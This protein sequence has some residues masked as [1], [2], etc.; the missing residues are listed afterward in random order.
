M[1]RSGK[2]GCRMNTKMH[3]DCSKNGKMPGAKAHACVC[4]DYLLHGMRLAIHRSCSGVFATSGR[5]DLLERMPSVRRDSALMLDKFCLES[6]VGYSN[7]FL[8]LCFHGRHNV[9]S[10]LAKQ[11]I[12]RPRSTA[13]LCDRMIWGRCALPV[14]NIVSGL[15]IDLIPSGMNGDTRDA[16]Y[17]VRTVSQ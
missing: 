14:E 16:V 15:F 5:F 6:T 13:R 4:N 2:N 3:A 1:T 11:A 12:G 8:L 17:I 7:G 9:I 10:N